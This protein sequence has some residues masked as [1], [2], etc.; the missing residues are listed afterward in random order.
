MG[1]DTQIEAK[2]SYN[3]KHE[4]LVL[5]TWLQNQDEFDFDIENKTLSWVQSSRN[6]RFDKGYIEHKVKGT[7]LEQLN[8][9]W[10]GDDGYAEVTGHTDQT[11]QN[12]YDEGYALLN[13]WKEDPT[14]KEIMEWACDEDD[15]DFDWNIYSEF[16]SVYG[17]VGDVLAYDIYR[18]DDG[19]L[20]IAEGSECDGYV[21]EVHKLEEFLMEWF[22]EEQEKR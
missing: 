3:E 8:L 1:Y 7:L 14:K 13:R 10:V 5:A 4:A 21:E 15:D 2:V 12:L 16:V 6:F 18:D 20:H 9:D 22:Q 17:D 19:E 11:W